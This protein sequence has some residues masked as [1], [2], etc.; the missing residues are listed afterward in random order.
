MQKMMALTVFQPWASFIA[1]TPEG[2]AKP[3][4]FRGEVTAQRARKYVGQRIV[5]HASARPVKRPEILDL[6]AK[7]NSGQTALIIPRARAILER[8]NDGRTLLLGH[9]LGT[10]LLGEP[11][12]T[13]DLLHR[14]PD[15]TRPLH[16]LWG[17]P[18]SEFRPFEPPVPCRGLQGFWVWP[19]KI[20]GDHHD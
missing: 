17:L 8:S 19:E 14:A 6:Y 12:Q 11:T 18:L 20:E 4:E 9:G 1:G 7:F 10:A 3:Y 16:H 15:S 13:L 5:I 2:T